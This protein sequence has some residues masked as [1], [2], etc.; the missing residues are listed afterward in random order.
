MAVKPTQDFTFSSDLNFSSGPASGNPT[1]VNPAGWPAVVQGFVPGAGIAAE[2]QNTV[3]NNLGLWTGWLLAGSNLAG[4][5]AHIVETNGVGQI[6]TALASFG[7]TASAF[8]PLYASENSGAP[9]ITAHFQNTVAGTAARL[10]ASTGHA[11]KLEQ[12]VDA[13]TTPGAV[14]QTVRTTEPNV[15]ASA[16]GDLSFRGGDYHRPS[17]RDDNGWQ[18]VHGSAGGLV[19]K[20]GEVAAEASTSSLGSLSSH[21]FATLV[22]ADNPVAGTTVH[23]RAVMEVGGDNTGGVVQVGIVDGTAGGTPIITEGDGG[24]GTKRTIQIYHATTAADSRYVVL[25]TDYVLPASGPRIFFLGYISG[26]GD[27]AY[28]RFASLEITGA[29]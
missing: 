25:E 27:I 19:R 24:A 18:Y 6:N 8:S 21:V 2:H 17:Y 26:T 15:G 28:I 16:E 13:V 20:Y 3:N 12:D 23:L 22:A 10:H 14:E 1:K 7:G 4:L 29:F 11:V 5:D 9:S